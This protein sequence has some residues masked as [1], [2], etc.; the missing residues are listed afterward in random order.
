MRVAGI[1]CGTNSLRLLVADAQSGLLTAVHREMRIVRLGAGVADTGRLSPAALR[2]TADAL[3]DYAA[4]I[5]SLGVERVRFVATSA[6]R[7][8]TN[9]TE[10]VAVVHNRLG[11]PAEIISGAEEAALSLRGVRAG[12]RAA[13]GAEIVVL[14]I[15]G[16][17]TELVLGAANERDEVRALISMDIGCVR[18]T[19]Q[20]LP[21]D[22]PT[23]AQVA[24][25]CRVVRAQLAGVDEQLRTAART[26]ILVG[27]AGSVT[28]VAGLALGLGAYD[29][30]A[31][32]AAVL[33]RVQIGQVSAELVAMTRAERQARAV[34]HPGRVDVIVAGAL[35]LREVTDWAEVD[36]VVVSECDI[37]DGITASALD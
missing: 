5:R 8:A 20:C 30:Q 15:G 14:D 18:L 4:T 37:L 33:S 19:E 28:T 24:Q 2:R 26:G 31:I 6:A 27:V 25:L 11:V 1:D 10:L 21:D 12:L 9:R 17:S 36:R 35:I 13:P 7:D 23:A 3:G 34:I 32:D 29:R 22:P 16:G